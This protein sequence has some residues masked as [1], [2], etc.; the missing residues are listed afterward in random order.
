MSNA[1]THWAITQRGL[2]PSAKIVLWYLSDCH[3][4]HFG[5]FP[6]QSRLAA[7]CE[8]SRSS[9]NTHLAKLE[10]AGL[11]RR[12]RGFD[13]ITHRQLPTRY[14]LACEA[15]F[16]VPDEVP[17]RPKKAAKPKPCAESG[18]G[19]LF[20]KPEKAM[21]KNEQKPCPDSSESR[22]QNLDT[23][24]VRE[25]LRETLSVFDAETSVSKEFEKFW[26]V[27]PRPQKRAESQKAFEAA[28]AQG[29]SA[30][31]LVYAA[32]AYRGEQAGNARQYV[33]Q[34]DTWLTRK[35]WQDFPMPALAAQDTTGGIRG[36]A[37]FWG[38]CIKGNKY[39][40]YGHISPDVAACMLQNGLATAAELQSV[41]ALP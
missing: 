3:N 7:D 30:E 41:G 24:L 17:A 9:I 15:D 23:N 12:V 18:H 33:A 16:A 31:W 37:E 2:S 28:V 19:D 39:V 34:S 8:M 27:H 4:P 21:S 26:K 6:S 25:T 10:A 13:P 22:V 5:C 29:V 14:K 32:N 36:M 35:R 11:I 40:P 1:A 38:G 20:A